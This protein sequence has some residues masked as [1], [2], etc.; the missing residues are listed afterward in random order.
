MK[1]VLVFFSLM[2]NTGS[3]IP[4]KMGFVESRIPAKEPNLSVTFQ[5]FNFCLLQTHNLNKHVAFLNF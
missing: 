3:K 4:P 2:I 1:T 5:H